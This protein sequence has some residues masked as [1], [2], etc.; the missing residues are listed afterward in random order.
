MFPTTGRALWSLFHG[1]FHALPAGDLSKDH[2]AA[3]HAFLQAFDAAV[4]E[5]GAGNCACS[6]KWPLL[7]AAHPWPTTTGTALFWWSV[8]MHD[9]VNQSIGKPQLVPAWRAAL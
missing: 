9:H 7:R 8:D 4:L 5:A 2:V 1:Y 6:K 3:V